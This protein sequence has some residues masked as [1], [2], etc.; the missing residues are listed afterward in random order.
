MTTA[1]DAAAAPEAAPEAAVEAAAEADAAA[2]A[3]EQAETPT[4]LEVENNPFTRT[5]ESIE[6]EIEAM[7][8][9]KA[10][11]KENIKEWVDAFAA[12][13]GG[14]QP[15]SQDKKLGSTRALYVAYTKATQDL[16][17]LKT[18]LASMP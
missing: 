15:S 17:H 18:E 2:S 6:K 1:P 3:A 7:E 5:K 13:H 4:Q 16:A 10:E 9:S 11:A 8:K 14:R 12:T